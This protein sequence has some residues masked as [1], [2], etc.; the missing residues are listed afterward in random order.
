[1]YQNAYAEA[2]LESPKEARMRE[3]EAITRS[4]EYMEAAEEA[5]PQSREAIVAL[6][7]LRQL[8]TIL[9]EDLADQRNALPPMLRAQV[10]SIGIWIMRE[11]EEIRL[12]NR[13]SFRPII[14][15]SQLIREGLA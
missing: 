15:I 12:E 9:L 8:W 4:I 13:T 6:N 14:D 10:I 7:F 3:R 1:M 5:G 2:L 11:A